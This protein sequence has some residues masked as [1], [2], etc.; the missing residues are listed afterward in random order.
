MTDLA[1]EN[2][3]L[4]AELEEYRQREL[5]GLRQR[6][7]EALQLAEHYRAEASRNAETGRQIASMYEQKVAKLE[8]QLE[9]GDARR[10]RN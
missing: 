2:E 9:A 10:G 7:A 4:R 5:D 3:Q 6:L 8:A 1:S